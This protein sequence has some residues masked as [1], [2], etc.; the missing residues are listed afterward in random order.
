MFTWTHH[1]IN[2]VFGYSV[3]SC[4]LII[5]R[6]LPTG[7]SAV[8]TITDIPSIMLPWN[9]QSHDTDSEALAGLEEMSY[10]Y[11]STVGALSNAIPCIYLKGPRPCNDA[12]F[13]A[14]SCLVLM[15]LTAIV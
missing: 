8:L 14:M 13:Y 2:R 11:R 6:Y 10:D 15:N 3:T 12:L 5:A 4:A 1:K 7:T 9:M